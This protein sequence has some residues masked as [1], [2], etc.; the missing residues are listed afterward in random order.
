M[1][2]PFDNTA[3]ASQALG[4]VFAVIGTVVASEPGARTTDMRNEALAAESA[5]QG[6]PPD[7]DDMIIVSTGG[8][9]RHLRIR[10]ERVFGPDRM[11][12]TLDV[13]ASGRGLPPALSGDEPTYLFMIRAGHL[14][15]DMEDAQPV[16]PL[17]DGGYA[18]CD[19]GYASW[20]AEAMK[21][22]QGLYSLPGTERAPVAVPLEFLDHAVVDFAALRA[23]QEA[24]I[25]PDAS[26]S[27]RAADRQRLDAFMDD[28]RELF[29]GPAYRVEDDLVRCRLGVRAER[30]ARHELRT[31][32]R[33]DAVRRRCETRHI[34]HRRNAL[35]AEKQGRIDASAAHMTA[36][37]SA[38]DDCV[39]PLYASGWPYTD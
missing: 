28:Q 27:E 29:S 23:L 36:F 22:Q 31:T 37:K 13:W 24:F 10:P 21:D 35:L 16:Y 3:P 2:P 39:G 19:P 6:L 18:L 34:H 20:E 30:A 26:E 7:S 33:Y 14:G 4:S 8:P 9:G 1:V 5:A 25:D 12:G 38:V 32:Y 11:P 15:M 17:A